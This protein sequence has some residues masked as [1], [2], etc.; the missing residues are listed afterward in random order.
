VVGKGCHGERP[1]ELVRAGAQKDQRRQDPT[2]S[3]HRGR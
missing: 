3:P 1:R 2:H